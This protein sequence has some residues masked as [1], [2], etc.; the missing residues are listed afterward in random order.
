MSY[1]YIQLVK[2]T[3]VYYSEGQEFFG[4]WV[5]NPKWR[6]DICVVI[7]FSFPSDDEKTS[8]VKNSCSFTHCPILG[9]RR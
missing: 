1:N 4:T 9:P 5:P 3:A 6:L 2:F 8:L 7:L